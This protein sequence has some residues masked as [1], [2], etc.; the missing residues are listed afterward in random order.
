MLAHHQGLRSRHRLCL[1]V[2]GAVVGGCLDGSFLYTTHP[3]SASG[4][5]KLAY[6]VS[7]S[8]TSLGSDGES[9]PCPILR[10][11]NAQEE[12]IDVVV[13]Q[14]RDDEEREFSLFP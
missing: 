10:M 1:I 8:T 2:L 6:D 4:R 9:S 11:P 12:L 3:G 13:G 7:G 5:E 14:R